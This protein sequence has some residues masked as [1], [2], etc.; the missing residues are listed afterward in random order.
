VSKTAFRQADVVRAVKSAKAEARTKAR[1]G[2]PKADQ[3][4]E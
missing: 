3:P 4:N 2:A 1:K